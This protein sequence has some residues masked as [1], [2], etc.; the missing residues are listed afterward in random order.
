M[1]GLEE[2]LQDAI[3]NIVSNVS[4]NFNSD[5]LKKTLDSLKPYTGAE[6][7][8]VVN[9]INNVIE[10]DKTFLEPL[11]D[12]LIKDDTIDIVK[13]FTPN[14]FLNI[15]SK[16]IIDKNDKLLKKIIKFYETHSE[17]DELPFVHKILNNLSTNYSLNCINSFYDLLEKT[18][19]GKV[20]NEIFMNPLLE[21]ISES[22]EYLDEDTLMKQFKL[23]SGPEFFHSVFG[24]NS[25][26]YQ[27][28]VKDSLKL[29]DFFPTKKEL[30]KYFDFIQYNA[31][32]SNFHQI[33]QELVISAN[34]LPVFEFKNKFNYFSKEKVSKYISSVDGFETLGDIFNLI[35]SIKN[36]SITDELL[37]VLKLYDNT[38]FINFLA[39]KDS[40]FLWTDDEE[41]FKQRL[42]FYSD[43]RSVNLFSSLDEERTFYA[44]GS[45][46]T[47]SKN[48]KYTEKLHNLLNLYS[49]NDEFFD[50][51]D[52]IAEFDESFT[53]KAIEVYSMQ[54]VVELLTSKIHE[55]RKEHILKCASIE[56]LIKTLDKHSIN[57]YAGFFCKNSNDASANILAKH[58]SKDQSVESKR[59]FVSTLPETF[60]MLKQLEKLEFK[61][62][63]SFIQQIFDDVY[64]K[65]TKL[66]DNLEKINLLEDFNSD[67]VYLMHPKQFF[68]F[69][70]LMNDKNFMTLVKTDFS[71]GD[72]NE[73]LDGRYAKNRLNDLTIL[74]SNVE[75]LHGTEM[76][77]KSV[78]L[79]N[80]LY[81]KKNNEFNAT[82]ESFIGA[83]INNSSDDYKKIIDFL[84]ND[85]I[86]KFVKRKISE[87]SSVCEE[88]FPIIQYFIMNDDKDNFVNFIKF[89]ED[90]SHNYGGH[91]KHLSNPFKGANKD[92]LT[93]YM[94][95]Q[96]GSIVDSYE[97]LE[98]FYDKTQSKLFSPT[99]NAGFAK[100]TQK[101]NLKNFFKLASRFKE[102][103]KEIIFQEYDKYDKTVRQVPEISVIENVFHKFLNDPNNPNL[104][105][106]IKLL[107]DSESLTNIKLINYLA[108]TDDDKLF[109]DV[110]DFFEKYKKTYDSEQIFPMFFYTKGNIQESFNALKEHPAID[111]VEKIFGNEDFN[112]NNQSKLI[113]YAI[114]NPDISVELSNIVLNSFS[115][116]TSK[117]VTSLLDNA[118]SFNYRNYIP[119][120]INKLQEKEFS[121]EED[122]LSLMNCI[123]SFQKEESGIS[124]IEDHFN[125][126]S[127][128]TRREILDNEL[129]L[130]DG[131]PSN[132]VKLIERGCNHNFIEKI[133]PEVLGV[134]DET[135]E[136]KDYQKLSE[137][138]VQS[139]SAVNLF[140]RKEKRDFANEF[141][142][143][144]NT[145]LEESQSNKQR[146]YRLRTHCDRLLNKLEKIK[147]ANLKI[148]KKN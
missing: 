73:F 46:L 58:I 13:N 50:I 146:S 26:P 21:K 142:A 91:H 96:L 103:I 65:N 147:A 116:E 143:Q 52:S 104:D 74:L 144:F 90:F 37:D 118:I 79:L 49:E 70:N 109:T 102:E 61:N 47:R 124:F 86:S 51:L 40:G 97:Q 30:S 107:K 148:N 54:N 56:Q 120:I 1:T 29:M 32:T 2:K 28:F 138:Y 5:M 14:S 57:K 106:T 125:E 89:Y 68:K 18:M 129:Y 82:R 132:Y 9:S 63:E 94:Y 34:D 113:Q 100:T 101:E 85:D 122:S 23:Y 77:D 27:S 39:E 24:N 93:Q 53:D 64:N 22:L 110:L 41:K 76:M 92:F 121:Y 145:F 11:L 135:F 128:S 136:L 114:L 36:E 130:F 20:V 112:I 67:F 119:L 33:M 126:I 108:S 81:T 69:T 123:I 72:I 131:A 38:H 80:K 133:N 60:K 88:F 3:I 7:V 139:L 98:L 44:C 140:H 59:N 115:S 78:T 84:S 6:T 19:L 99:E 12:F 17:L 31:G 62:K 134:Y 45:F 48:P 87:D 8:E 71:Y 25:Y 43:S 95:D 137:L 105:K 111:Y 4:D 10:D 83:Y 55:S 75:Q 141:C 16:T 66:A 42:N 117:I 15:T 35:N 127:Y